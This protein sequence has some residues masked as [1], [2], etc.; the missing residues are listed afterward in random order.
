MPRVERYASLDISVSESCNLSVQDSEHPGY[1][2]LD[3]STLRSDV[4]PK[5][6][7]LEKECKYETKDQEYFELEDEEPI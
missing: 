6:F 3:K 5:Y 4:E 2:E 1:A 7:E